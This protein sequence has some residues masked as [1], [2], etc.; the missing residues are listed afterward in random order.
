[1]ALALS[2]SANEHSERSSRPAQ[3]P[4]PEPVSSKRVRA[5]YDFEPTE[6]GEL[7][8]Q[9]DDIIV[10]LAESY[11]DWWKGELFG[12]QGIFPVNYVEEIKEVDPSSAAADEANVLHEAK[13]I[14]GL[15]MMLQK[16]DPR[17]DNFAEND[18]LQVRKSQLS[19]ALC[20]RGT[21]G[22][23]PQMS[24]QLSSNMHSH[25]LGFIQQHSC[26]TT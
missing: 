2:L 10:V 19:F 20:L 22:P 9:K 5:L 3:R 14:D 6:S 24:S 7:G 21:L 16:V 18:A 23:S 4:E 8:F 11:K 13:N 15:L 26:R 17:V 12:R 25:V 1:M